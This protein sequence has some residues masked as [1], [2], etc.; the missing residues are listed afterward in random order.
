MRILCVAAY[1]KPARVYGGPVQSL[2]ALCEGLA[3]AGAEVTVFTTNANGEQAALDLPT[4]RPLDV[5]GVQVHYFPVSKWVSR[6]FPFYFYSSQLGR[7]CREIIKC[8]DV[9]Y[10]PGNWTYPFRV[11]ARAAITQGNRTWSA[12]AGASWTGPCSRD[13]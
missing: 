9:L 6:L 11:G 7:A 8:Y 2:A 10:L 3:R 5:G 12:H 13:Y 1:Y 4:D